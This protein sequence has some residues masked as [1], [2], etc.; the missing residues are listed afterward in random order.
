MKRGFTLPE[1]ILTMTIIGIVVA[2][3]IPG[4]KSGTQ[5]KKADAMYAK[6]CYILD[7]ALTQTMVKSHI[8]N[9]EDVDFL[10]LVLNLNGQ[11]LNNNSFEFKDGAILAPVANTHFY[12]VT[13]PSRLS[14]PDRYYLIQNSKDGIDC[15]QN[16]QESM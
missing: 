15:S 12:K 13:F 14:I 2:L 16:G 3:T 5:A 11:Y 10:Q 9:P 1:V 6:Y 7:S 8:V 4:L